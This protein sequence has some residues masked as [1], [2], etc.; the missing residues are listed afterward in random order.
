MSPA[1]PGKFE[2]RSTACGSSI[3]SIAD[4]VTPRG[5]VI[6]KKEKAGRAFRAGKGVVKFGGE[7]EAGG[8]QAPSYCRVTRG[9]EVATV[10]VEVRTTVRPGGITPAHRQPNIR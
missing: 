9:G 8:R 1:V 7:I 6:H 4:E 10:V 3:T 5:L 2:L